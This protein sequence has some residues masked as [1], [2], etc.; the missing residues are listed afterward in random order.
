MAQVSVEQVGDL[1]LLTQWTCRSHC[2]VKG[3]GGA[4]ARNDYKEA[5]MKLGNFST[6]KTMWSLLNNVPFPKYA[7]GPELRMQ[8]AGGGTVTALSLFRD[9][10][11][12]SWEHHTG[13]HDGTLE[14]RVC[15][16]TRADMDAV[17]LHVV[18]EVIGGNVSTSK[19]INFAGL[20][21]VDKTTA[22][23]I[24]FNAKFEVWTRGHVALEL[25]TQ[26]DAIMS[27]CKLGKCS[28]SVFV[29]H[30]DKISPKARGNC[31]RGKHSGRKG[32]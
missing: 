10:L 19:P 25:T 14:W 4:V 26:F 9:S 13:K 30:R 32:K 18:T 20:R 28:P 8:V 24:G 21:L 7:F 3:L 23:C 27:L 17:W 22:R 1:P 15:T 2:K 29:P 5:Q 11:E 6:I 12:P 16:D 31:H